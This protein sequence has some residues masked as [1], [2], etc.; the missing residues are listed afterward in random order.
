MLT[1]I[2]IIFSLFVCLRLPCLAIACILT[3][4]ESLSLSFLFLPSHLIYSF[5][6]CFLPSYLPSFLPSLLATFL[7][8]TILTSS[9]ISFSSTAPIGSPICFLLPYCDHT[10]IFLSPFLSFLLYLPSFLIDPP[11]SSTPFSLVF[12]L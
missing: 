11:L 10:N 4:Y 3:T 2:I 12:Q 8:V 5:L 9:I 6:L 7:T 1:Q